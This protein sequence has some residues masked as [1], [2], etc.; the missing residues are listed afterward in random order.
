MPT[1]DQ[2]ETVRQWWINDEAFYSHW[3]AEAEGLVDECDNREEAKIR[4]AEQ[5]C[6]ETYANIPKNVRQPHRELLNDALQEVDWHEIAT[7]FIAD[8]P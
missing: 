3:F 4:L 8:V 7:E 1:N 5:M 6:A 2:T